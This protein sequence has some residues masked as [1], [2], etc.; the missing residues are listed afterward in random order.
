MKGSHG[1][2]PPGRTHALEVP[3]GGG[4]NPALLGAG[5]ALAVQTGREGDGT[6]TPLCRLGGAE[7][8]NPG[9]VEGNLIDQDFRA[10]SGEPALSTT[11]RRAGPDQAV[12]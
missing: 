6:P 8:G 11:P 1:W 7:G 5:R 3:K 2:R 9:V 12:G 10:R 4:G